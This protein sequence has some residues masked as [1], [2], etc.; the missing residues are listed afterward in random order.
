MA[1]VLGEAVDGLAQ[2]ARTGRQIYDAACAACHGRDGRGM[3]A[4]QSDY[5]VAPPD[6]SDCSFSTREPAADWMA[7]SHA[8]GPVRAFSRL[9]PAFGEALSTEELERAV[10]HARSFCT[11]QAWPRGEL[12][13]EQTAS[14][15]ALMLARATGTVQP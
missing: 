12:N 5:P 9:M 11:D 13:H 4:A 15:S 10:S 2:T 14:D 7:V 6:F 3:P 1:A 8:G